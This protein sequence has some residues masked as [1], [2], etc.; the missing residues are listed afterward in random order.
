MDALRRESQRAVDEIGQV[1]GASIHC[2]SSARNSI[3]ILKNNLHHRGIIC[4]GIAALT[5]FC[6]YFP[7]LAKDSSAPAVESING[8]TSLS[9]SSAGTMGFA[10]DYSVNNNQLEQAVLLSRRAVNTDPDDIEAH[11]SYAEALENKLRAL[12]ET[13]HELASECITQWL[14]VLRNEVGEE[15]GLG[16]HGISVMGHL[17]DD[18]TRSITARQRLVSIAGRAPKPWETDARYLKSVLHQTSVN[19]KVLKHSE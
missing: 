8:Y 19:G 10:S 1:T 7:S 2:T 18:D 4:G 17:Y 16:F 6:G 5:I 12:K 13:D 14:I 15:K 3:M 9:N 11:Q